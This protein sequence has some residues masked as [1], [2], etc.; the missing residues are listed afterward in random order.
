MWSLSSVFIAR[1]AIEGQAE[2]WAKVK[3]HVQ[4][5]LGMQ[6]AAGGLV[7]FVLDLFATLHSQV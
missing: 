1:R 4:A 2:I 5:E 6:A 7:A 3:E